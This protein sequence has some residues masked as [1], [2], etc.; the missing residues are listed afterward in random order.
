MGCY[1]GA[2]R[3]PC[4]WCETY[5][6]Q[7][8]QD[9]PQA[10]NGTILDTNNGLFYRYGRGTKTKWTQNENQALCGLYIELNN[11]REELPERDS[12]VIREKGDWEI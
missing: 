1:C 8:L 12:L 5:W 10:T 3:P 6:M 4:G 11:I 2:T 9:D 7:E